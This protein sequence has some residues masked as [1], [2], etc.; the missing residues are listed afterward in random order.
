MPDSGTVPAPASARSPRLTLLGRPGC[1]LC[2]YA[3]EALA[4][5]RAATGVDWL[6]LDVDSDPELAAEYGGRVP[7]VLLD[8]REHCWFRV[9]EERLLRD[10]AG[11]D[12]SDVS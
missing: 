9:E 6:E 2:D 3:R 12:V 1:H 10:L 11:T 7:V 5:V 4:R 8:G